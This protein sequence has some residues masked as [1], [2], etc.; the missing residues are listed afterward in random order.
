VVAL[1][2]WYNRAPKGDDDDPAIH[3]STAAEL[4]EVIDRILA[5]TVDHMAPPMIQVSISGMKR[6]PVLEVGLGQDRGFIGYTAAD[7]GWTRGTGNPA[8][9]VDYVYMGN[10]SQVSARVKAR[11]R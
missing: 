1:D 8:T 6:S 10:H 5:E 4:N 11:S 2:I 7:G 3:V 9:L